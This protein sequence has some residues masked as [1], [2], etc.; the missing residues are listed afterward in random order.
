MSVT[1]VRL[2]RLQ[3]LRTAEKKREFTQENRHPG[4]THVKVEGL[5][6]L[7]HE[8][9]LVRQEVA[10]GLVEVPCEK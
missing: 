9:P 7:G 10:V 1:V 8:R 2:L 5:S 6:S 3:R 4:R